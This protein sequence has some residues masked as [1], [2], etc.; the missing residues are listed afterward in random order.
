MLIMFKVAETIFYSRV[1]WCDVLSVG[2]NWSEVN[3]LDSPLTDHCPD[4]NRKKEIFFYAILGYI[5][6]GS[7]WVAMWPLRVTGKYP[8]D[9]YS[10]R[11]IYVSLYNYDP[12][13]SILWLI[14]NF[15]NLSYPITLSWKGFELFM[16]IS[17]FVLF[18]KQ[19]YILKVQ[20]CFAG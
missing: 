15:L 14:K 6:H 4:E 11:S 17:E 16:Q 2:K 3:I 1:I 9:A 7:W 18:A 5:R 20:F 8:S 19:K 12:L 10:K 13:F